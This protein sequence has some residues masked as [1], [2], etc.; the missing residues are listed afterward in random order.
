MDPALAHK[1]CEGEN[2][3]IS[4]ERESGLRMWEAKY[5]FQKEPMFVGETFG[6]KACN[7]RTRVD[8]WLTIDFHRQGFEFYTP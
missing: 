2:D 7:P 4:G 6:R 3:D 8:R 5:Q 1:A